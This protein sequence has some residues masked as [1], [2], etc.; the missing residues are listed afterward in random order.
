MYVNISRTVYHEAKVF[1]IM[2]MFRH[3]ILQGPN[4]WSKTCIWT[5]IATFTWV[6]Y[7]MM[8]RGTH[9]TTTSPP[10]SWTTVSVWFGTNL[11]Y[12][13]AHEETTAIYCTMG[14][15]FPLIAHLMAL[16]LWDYKLL[17]IGKLVWHCTSSY[18][19]VSVLGCDLTPIKLQRSPVVIQSSGLPQF[20]SCSILTEDLLFLI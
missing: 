14:A 17:L 19:S 9:W 6:F 12:Y 20:G 3:K 8:Q 4:V 5:V 2:W 16:A 11:K 7:I 13:L 10:H 1:Q 15:Y 18:A